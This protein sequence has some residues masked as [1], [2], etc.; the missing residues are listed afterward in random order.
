[1][2]FL[3]FAEI[4]RL[5]AKVVN[6]FG[7]LHGIRDQ[8]LLESAIAY[9]ETLYHFKQ[10]E[11]DPLTLAASYA[12]HIIKNHAFLDGNK[13]IGILAML[14]FLEKNGLELE[15]TNNVL[16]R[17]SIGIATSKLSEKQ[18]VTRLR[19]YPVKSLFN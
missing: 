9:P 15:V 11:E 13:R 2:Q 3:S 18:V 12:Y 16:Y 8:A 10:S 5:Q 19:K 6:R 17:L 4:M 14:S 1:M 7:G